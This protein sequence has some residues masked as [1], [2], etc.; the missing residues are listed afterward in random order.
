MVDATIKQAGF[1][2][3]FKSKVAGIS[4]DNPDG[5]NRQKII[6]K[7]RVGE[8]VLLKREP[9]NAYDKHAILITTSKNIAIGY[10]PSGD[11]RLAHHIDSGGNTEAKIISITGGKNLIEKLF[12]L[13]GKHYGVVIQITKIDPDLKALK[14]YIDENKAIEALI[15][16]AKELEETKPL[17]AL[18]KYKEAAL[19]ITTLDNQGLPASAWRRVQ[20][21][22]ERI[23]LLLEQQKQKQ[24][25]LEAIMH[26]RS[27]NDP[28][29]L[30]NKTQKILDNRQ[31]R[32]EKS[33]SK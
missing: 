27:L 31:A 13:K 5:V 25:A 11:T 21:P 16:A 3:S 15:K 6:E 14:P 29:G 10:I 26:W 33:L 19:R 17:E 2:K 20:H 23:S 32:L 30:P 28:Q 4:H 1:Q 9:Q 7:C 8:T 24:E 22:V 18:L 12:R